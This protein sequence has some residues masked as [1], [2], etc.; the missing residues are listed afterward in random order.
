MLEYIAAQ[1]RIK[2]ISRN[3][4]DKLGAQGGRADLGIHE[5][6]TYDRTN[7]SSHLLIFSWSNPVC[8]GALL[9]VVT[10]SGRRIL[11]V[12]TPGIDIFEC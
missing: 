12:S 5:N 11:I 2:T 8:L 7:E 10:A 9:G 4:S 3:A 1:N 6:K